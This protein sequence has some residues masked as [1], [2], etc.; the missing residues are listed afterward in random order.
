LLPLGVPESVAN[1]VSPAREPRRQISLVEPV[2]LPGV[3]IKV[4]LK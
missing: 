2:S 3:S 4:A 1:T